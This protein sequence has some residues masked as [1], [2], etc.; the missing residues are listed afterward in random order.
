MKN[1]E[2]QKKPIQREVAENALLKRDARVYEL[3]IQGLT[4]EAI[5]SEVGFGGPSGAWQAYQRIRSEIIIESLEDSRQLEL[6]RLDELQVA[7]W[8]RAVDGELPAAHAVL[9]IMDRRAKLLGLD[10][11]EKVEINQ[12]EEWP[13]DLK[14]QVAEMEKMIDF[15]MKYASDHGIETEFT[16]RYLSKS[17]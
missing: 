6:M 13:V 4:F 8:D 3:R 16:K 2:N 10:R 7:L 9:K 17:K 11:P 1:L 12:I 15:G 14:E 5:A